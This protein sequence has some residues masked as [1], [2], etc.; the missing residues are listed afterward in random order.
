MRVS[1]PLAAFVAAGVLAAP[2]QDPRLD[3]VPNPRATYGGWVADPDRRLAPATRDSLDGW[4]TRLERETGAE[5]AVVVVDSTSGRSVREFAVALHNFWGVGKAGRDNGVLLLWVPAQREVFVSI[6]YGLESRIPDARVAR[7]LE[8]DLFPDFRRGEFDRG[9]LRTVAALD[10]EVRAAGG[11]GGSG[12]GS[13][14]WLRRATRAVRGPWVGAGFAAAGIA[15]LLGL[16]RWQARRRPRGC[17]K[18][19]M[20]MRRLSEGAEVAL[21]D[22]GDRHEEGIGSVD[23]DVW[24]CDRCGH[25]AKLPFARWFSGYKRCPE[26]GRKALKTSTSVLQAATE[27]TPGRER[28][29]ERCTF[30][31]HVHTYER[32]IPARPVRVSS[33]GGG[34]FG[35]GRAGGSGAGGR[36]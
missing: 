3:W 27:A 34:S 21:L 9:V 19:R 22:P 16:Y 10:R 11:G 23:Y 7:I 32:V 29:E 26:C 14:S 6:G 25:V 13:A 4:I 36:Y 1:L 33:G 24:V 8:H 30:C 18:C 17:P 2:A 28:V 31:D 20:P 5:M 12:G 15:F 35:G